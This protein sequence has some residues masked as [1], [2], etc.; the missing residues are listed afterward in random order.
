MRRC[1]SNAGMMDTPHLVWC[2]CFRGW[3]AAAKPVAGRKARF[4]VTGGAAQTGYEKKGMCGTHYQCR[5]SRSGPVVRSV[6]HVYAVLVLDNVVIVEA[7]NN[8]K[9][10]ISHGIPIEY[11]SFV[12]LYYCCID[13]IYGVC[14]CAILLL[15]LALTLTLRISMATGCAGCAGYRR[16]EERLT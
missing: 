12:V 9:V 13:G 16:V 7:E 10:Q 6:V 3:P 2:P 5:H 11:G 15:A 14:T 4:D 8:L 1:D